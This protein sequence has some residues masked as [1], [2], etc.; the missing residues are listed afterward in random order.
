MD[1]LCRNS[2]NSDYVDALS[3]DSFAM[4]IYKCLHAYGGSE[5]EWIFNK[6]DSSLKMEVDIRRQRRI[7][8]ITATFV[9]SGF[10]SELSSDEYLQI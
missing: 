3:R 8:R 7:L 10:I 5:R 1:L 6:I 2:Q 4:M 9:E